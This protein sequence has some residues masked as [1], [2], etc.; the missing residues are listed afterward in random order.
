MPLKWMTF[1]RFGTRGSRIENSCSGRILGSAGGLQGR[2]KTR[3]CELLK[4]CHAISALAFMTSS[5]VRAS[6]SDISA[7]HP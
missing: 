1:W 6:S 4:L 2:T 3:P 7:S 5:V